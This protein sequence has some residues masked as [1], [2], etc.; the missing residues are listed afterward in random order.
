MLWVL[1]R[2]I[3]IPKH[4]VG[5]QKDPL[6]ETVLLSTHNIIFWVGTQKDHLIETVLLST[7]NMFWLIGIKKWHYMEARERYKFM[8]E[9]SKF[10]KY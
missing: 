4:V 2:T 3:P 6:N 5:T 8:G 9:S 1:K 10:P 7:H